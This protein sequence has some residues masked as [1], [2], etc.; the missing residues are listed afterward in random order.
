MF[1]IFK[2]KKDNLPAQAG[3]GGHAD[4]NKKEEDKKMN[5]PGK[6]KEKDYKK[7]IEEKVSVYVMPERFRAIHS[8]KSKAKTTG[9]III[10]GGVIFLIAVSALLYYYLIM[11][12][13]SEPGP[14]ATSTDREVVAPAETPA[15]E[16]PANEPVQEPAVKSPEE[17]YREIKAEFDRAAAFDDFERATLKYGS[18]NRIREM[19]KE[20]EQAEGLPESFKENI[21]SFVA[22]LSMPKLREISGIEAGIRGNVAT[23]SAITRDSAQSGVI[24]MVREDNAWKL[25][26]ESWE[27]SE[28]EEPEEPDI[29]SELIDF[30]DGVDSDSDGLT[31]KEESLLGSDLSNK[32]S[33]GDGYEDFSEVM[34]LYNPAGQGKLED[35][36][37]I[38]E[39]E[40]NTYSYNL[41]YPAGWTVSGVGGDDSVMLR[42][43]DNH[44]IQVITQ[45][46]ANIQSIEDWY[47]QQFN[48]PG[49]NNSRLISANNWQ[50]VRNEDGLTVYLTDNE[51]NSIF[52]ITYNLGNQS[53]L[54]YKNIFEMIIK[55]FKIA[56]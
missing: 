12:G 13:P 43:G 36:V 48:V 35:S 6:S 31:D 39:Y 49:I 10:V 20:K 41:I 8:Q 29:S 27:G 56:N 3:V 25:E 32:D 44:F 4:K 42:S 15:T 45:S 2:K 7:E 50:G 18:K 46:N 33:D 28:E 21:V 1:N 24:Q 30:S 19:E 54:E 9:L 40:N 34:N 14:T 16:K 47:K 22:R 26:S 52:T 37:K 5:V 38:K 53:V 51:R 55:S 23:L 17:S 11:G